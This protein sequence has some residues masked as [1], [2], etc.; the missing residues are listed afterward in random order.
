MVCTEWLAA[1]EYTLLWPA[2]NHSPA[3][4][5]FLPVCCQFYTTIYLYALYKEQVY[6]EQVFVCVYI[7]WHDSE[8]PCIGRQWIC[9]LYKDYDFVLVC[10]YIKWHG[11]EMPCFGRQWMCAGCTDHVLVCVYIK[12]YD[13]DMLCFWQRVSID[14]SRREEATGEATDTHKAL[15]IEQLTRT[16]LTGCNQ[17]TPT[18]NSHI[19]THWG[20]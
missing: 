3:I 18:S 7:K 4:A 9:A 20:R 16:G 12:W 11:S 6:K 14:L 10:V 13:P 15:N 5:Q 2:S 1:T 17:L 19:L 8:M